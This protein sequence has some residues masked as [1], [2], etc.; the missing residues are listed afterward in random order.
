MSKYNLDVIDEDKR[1]SIPKE[2]LC[3]Y[4]GL[5][6]GK[7]EHR[8]LKMSKYNLDV[9]D[10]DKRDSIPR[11]GRKILGGVAPRSEQMDVTR[12]GMPG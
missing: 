1:D 2:K 3:R 6:L 5:A 12:H 10:E 4:G 9:I 11:K 7:S 8:T